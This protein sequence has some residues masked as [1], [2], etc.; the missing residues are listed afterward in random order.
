MKWGSFCPCLEFQGLLRFGAFL[1]LRKFLTLQPRLARYS[2]SSHLPF[3]G[4]GFC[5]DTHRHIR[6]RSSKSSTHLL[7][8][9]CLL[10][11]IYERVFHKLQSHLKKKDLKDSK[12]LRAKMR[13]LAMGLSASFLNS[14]Q[15]RL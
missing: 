6:L 15:Q 8:L 5:T 4:T 1:F 14:L 7:S 3:S 11:T 13:L 12:A 10:L 2:E 9:L